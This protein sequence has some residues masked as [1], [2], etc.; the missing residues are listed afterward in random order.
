MTVELANATREPVKL[1]AGTKLV[2][3]QPFIELNLLQDN[4]G[5]TGKSV[6]IFSEDLDI[7]HLDEEQ[8]QKL[9]NVLEETGAMENGKHLGKTSLLEHAIN[10]SEN[11]P[12]RQQPYRVP[13]VK[14]KI[15][16]EVQK[17]LVSNVIPPSSSPWASSV[18]LVQKPS[19]EVRFCADYRHVNSITKKDPYPLPR[20]DETLDA[21]SD[22]RYFT[23]LDLQSGYWQVPVREEDKKKTAFVT[24][25]GHWEFNVLPFGLTRAPPTCQCLMDL[26]LNRLHWAHCLV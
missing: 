7:D 19:G 14:R 4:P 15:I 11:P 13:Q 17:M 16:E 9:L 3:L 2:T 8:K 22:A 5:K 26:V 6:N 18:V 25:H 23:T 1:F 20:I 12:V 10:T 21:L 24:H